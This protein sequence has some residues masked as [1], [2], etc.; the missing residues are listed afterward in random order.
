MDGLE[1]EVEGALNA[2]AE[3]GGLSG[4]HLGGIDFR[5]DFE[6]AVDILSE[7]GL[8]EQSELPLVFELRC[9]DQA[10]IPDIARSGSWSSDAKCQ[11]PSWFP[12]R[13][14]YGRLLWPT[15]LGPK[16]RSGR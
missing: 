14:I 1:G 13:R 9:L 12:P 4:E 7:L 2:M 8:A 16:A 15:S 6:D 10:N 3:H 11:Q 5:G